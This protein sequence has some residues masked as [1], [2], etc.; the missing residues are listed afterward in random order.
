MKAKKSG[1]K[2]KIVM[3]RSEWEKMGKEAGWGDVFKTVVKDIADPLK[4]AFE[5][6]R[7]DLRTYEENKV[8]SLTGDYME[9][10]IM[11]TPS[12]QID[13]KEVEVNLNTLVSSDPDV[14]LAIPKALMFIKNPSPALTPKAIDGMKILLY[15][16][17]RL[18]KESKNYKQSLEILKKWYQQK[19]ESEKI[20]NK[21]KNPYL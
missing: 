18:P 9:Q 14:L 6:E 3:S 13:M 17:S 12:S 2:V 5:P 1:N 7:A 21:P 11:Q 10:K 4:K 8:H 20:W 15:R 19:K 16:L